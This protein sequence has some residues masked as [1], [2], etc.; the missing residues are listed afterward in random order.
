M[1][2]PAH[3]RPSP[4]MRMTE[5]IHHESQLKT[6]QDALLG[7]NLSKKP[8]K[9]SNENICLTK[10]S[11]NGS[12]G[13]GKQTEMMDTQKDIIL[14]APRDK[15]P[16]TSSGSNMSNTYAAF[17]NG[18]VILD[19]NFDSRNMTVTFSPMGV[20]P[21]IDLQ[22]SPSIDVPS[23]TQRPELSQSNSTYSFA[24]NVNPDKSVASLCPTVKIEEQSPPLA[25]NG[26]RVNRPRK[27]MEM[28][29]DLRGSVSG[30]QIVE[31]S[32]SVESEP[33]A[34]SMT[35]DIPFSKD[36]DAVI[37]SRIVAIVGED[38]IDK[39]NAFA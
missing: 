20:S 33:S 1:S 2:E 25:N 21:P 4:K 11:S 15:A 3:A 37:P 35:G 22:E 24:S 10:K 29:P 9:E 36:I 6:G 16:P 5:S 23:Q 14:D 8:A 18:T 27:K 34:V 38:Q 32:H 31:Q 7:S 17:A 26:E 13:T 12:S 19:R 28:P 39:G 30:G